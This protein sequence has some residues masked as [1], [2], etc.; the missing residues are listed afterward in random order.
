MPVLPN[1]RKRLEASRRGGHARMASM[2]KLQRQNLS[3]LAG[4]SLLLAR[5]KGYFVSLG[6]KGAA[7]RWK[8][9]AAVLC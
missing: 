4:Q 3:S 5:G 2:T 9:E 8:K 1:E 7:V 6:I